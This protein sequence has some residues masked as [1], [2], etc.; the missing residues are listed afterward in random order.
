[1]NDLRVATNRSILT[2]EQVTQ[3]R[4]HA[5]GNSTNM[6]TALQKL[7]DWAAES[8]RDVLAQAFAYRTCSLEELRASKPIFELLSFRECT[9]RSCLL[10]RRAP[11]IRALQLVLADPFNVA[12][13]AWARRQLGHEAMN[14][15]VVLTTRD[16]L[17]IFLTEQ[18]NQFSA[19]D[20]FAPEAANTAGEDDVPLITL[21]S[22]EADERP[23]VKFVDSTIYDALKAQASDIH[24]EGDETGLQVQYRI[25]GVLVPITRV[26]GTILAEQI[27]SR[28]KVMA[29]L[30]I[31]ERRIP[32]DGR[33][34]VRVNAREIDFRVSIMPSLFGEDAV[35]RL[36]D[37]RALTE[38]AQS[39]R[40]DHLGLDAGNMAQIR[41]LAAKPHGMLLVTGPTGSGKTTTLYAAITEIHTG[42]DKIV[43]IE[44]PVEYRLPRVLQ[45]PVNEKKGLTFARGLRSL[46]RHDPDKIM[47]GEI[48]DEETAQIAVQ[49]ALTGHLVLTSVHANS[50]YDVLGRFMHMGVD[51]YSFA[52]A[53]NG[54]VAQRLMRLNCPHCA[55]PAKP[56]PDLLMKFSVAQVVAASWAYRTGRGCAHCRGTGYQGRIAIAEVLIIDDILREHIASRSPVTTLKA[57]ARERGLIGMQ[58]TA[59]SIIAEGRTTLAELDRVA[60]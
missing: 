35:L 50:V 57:L 37:R 10:I 53:L 45:I 59:L 7:N 38:A 60:S 31:A 44:D 20:G 26:S 4:E 25:D 23:A 11:S 28:I 3:A 15:E 18:E 27:V 41:T 8:C 5:L 24:L 34:R 12:T 42:R 16:D 49:A 40:L 19:I 30:D 46:L 33:F 29:E 17:A 22:I 56:E 36:L 48:R 21:S 54:I 9:N 52:S 13:E 58:Q 47:V 2:P 39:L 43:T 55:E 6:V 32:Q 51:P 1:M 14:L